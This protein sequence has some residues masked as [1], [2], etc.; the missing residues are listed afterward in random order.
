MS[1]NMLT[2]KM[3]VLDVKVRQVGKLTQPFGKTSCVQRSVIGI[4]CI[5]NRYDMSAVLARD[6]A[7]PH[8]Q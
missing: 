7:G 2:A 4:P 1:A 8:P 3:V 6:F 5:T